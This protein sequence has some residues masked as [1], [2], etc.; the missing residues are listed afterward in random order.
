[1]KRKEAKKLLEDCRALLGEVEDA[2]ANFR[3]H[4]PRAEPWERAEA[5]LRHAL[6]ALSQGEAEAE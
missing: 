2:V 5:H 4:D 1:M 3:K 6:T